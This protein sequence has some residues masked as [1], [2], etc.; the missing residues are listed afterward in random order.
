MIFNLFFF[1]GASVDLLNLSSAEAS[2]LLL[3]YMD[4][5]AIPVLPAGKIV[6][7]VNGLSSGNGLLIII[8]KFEFQ[9]FSNQ[10]LRI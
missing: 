9:T 1:V 2:E 8:L 7:S 10:T 3:K 6:E 5:L 4:Q